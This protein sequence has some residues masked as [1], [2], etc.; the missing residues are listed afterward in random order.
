[1]FSIEV[2]EGRSVMPRLHQIHVAGYRYPRRATC[3]QI[4]VDR[5]CIRATRIRCKRGI[6]LHYRSGP[7]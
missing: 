2:V 4:Q 6:G 7:S 3:I 1:M 5:N